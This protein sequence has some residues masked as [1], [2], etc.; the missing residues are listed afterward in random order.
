MSLFTHERI[1]TTLP[2]AKAVRPVAEKLITCSKN[3]GLH[4][5]R[6]LSSIIYDAK[7]VTKLMED[8]GKRFKNRCG[9][10]TRIYKCGFRRGDNAPMAIIELVDYFPE[11]KA[12][13]AKTD[14][15]SAGK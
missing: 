7:V 15:T 9:G 1:K 2:K 11:K 3:T 13:A 12:S 5:L 8:I 10:Y 14:E 4:T 6:K